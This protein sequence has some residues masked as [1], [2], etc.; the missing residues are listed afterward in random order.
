MTFEELYERA[1]QALYVAKS[2]KTVS[3][4]ESLYRL[5]IKDKVGQTPTTKVGV[6]ELEA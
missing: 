2:P 6:F 1:D 5:H 4:Y 3:D